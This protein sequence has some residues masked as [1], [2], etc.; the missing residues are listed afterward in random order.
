MGIYQFFSKTPTP[1]FL[2]RFSYHQLPGTYIHTHEP[3]YLVTEYHG[4]DTEVHTEYI[5][6]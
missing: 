4:T 2:S 1:L 5:E 6:K 3:V